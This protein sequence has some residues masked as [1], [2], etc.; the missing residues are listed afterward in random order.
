VTS[1]TATPETL[2]EQYDPLGVHLDD[3]YPF[4]AHARRQAPIFFSPKAN[5]WVV[6][7]L[8]DVKKVLRD[9][10]TYSS[11]NS[12]RPPAPLSPKVDEILTSVYPWMSNLI[13]MDG[14]EHRQQRTP[15]AAMLSP[16]QVTALEPYIVE[17]A[18]TLVDALIAGDRPADFMAAYANRLPVSVIGHLVGFPP[19]QHE[20]MGHLSRRAAAIAIGH[21]FESED[22][23]I[24]VAHDWLRYQALVGELVRERRAAPRADL[25][26]SLVAALAPGTGPLSREQEGTVVFIAFGLALAGHITTSALLGNGMRHL[27]EHPD[28]WRLLCERPDLIPNAIEEIARFDTPTHIFMRQTTTETT[29]AGQRLPAGAE[30][31]I[32]LAG[33]NRDESAFDRAD[34]FDITRKMETS[35][36]VFGHGAHYCVGAGLARRE[37]EVSLRVLTER[38]PGLRLVPDQQITTRPSLSQRGPLSLL[39]DW[40]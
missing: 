23:Q 6:T 33:G 21:R 27:L 18:I 22:E 36:V 16:E 32:W 37:V 10:K 2:G 26:S 39:V 25:M 4:Y 34:E 9:A 19:E 15:A 14:A 12:L 5:A 35:H 30:V 8:R 1:V 38:L 24:E 29:L 28:Q 20:E 13:E 31:L 7:R 3:P 17:Q 40:S 11:C